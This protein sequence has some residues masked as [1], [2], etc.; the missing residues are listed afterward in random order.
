M[1]KINKNYRV[2]CGKKS[3]YVAASNDIH[4]CIQ[5]FKLL[6]DSLMKNYL[7]KE[8][9]VT[10]IPTGLTNYYSTLEIIEFMNDV[11]SSDAQEPKWLNFETLNLQ[12][13]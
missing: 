13:Q 10:F 3:H 9:G 5:F 1:K 11:F 4:A 8:M 6:D 2:I 7:G 12:Q